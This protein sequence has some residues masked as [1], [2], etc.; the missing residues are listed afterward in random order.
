MSDVSTFIQALDS[1]IT[2]NAYSSFFDEERPLGPGEYMV[3][4]DAFYNNYNPASWTWTLQVE[5]VPIPASVWL[6]GSA[7][8]LMGV[9]RRKAA[10]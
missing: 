8:G 2:L 9:M 5:P 10:A 7:L 1:G 4:H 3:F 6:F